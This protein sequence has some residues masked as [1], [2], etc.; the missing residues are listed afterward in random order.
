MLPSLPDGRLERGLFE[1]E[2]AGEGTR[3]ARQYL[4]AQEDVCLVQNLAP[5]MDGNGLAALVDIA[6]PSCSR[7]RPQSWSHSCAGLKILFSCPAHL[8]LGAHS[9]VLIV[10]KPFL[11]DHP[12]P[13]EDQA[14]GAH[15]AAQAARRPAHL[16]PARKVPVET[17]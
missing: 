17:D 6:P 4:S 14:I 7:L 9:L 10:G 5:R 12:I 15:N 3:E 11:V 2:E 8:H 1:A 13:L 16:S